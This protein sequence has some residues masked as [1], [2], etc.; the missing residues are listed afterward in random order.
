MTKTWP[1][2]SRRSEKEPPPAAIFSCQR[3]V[4]SVLLS[5]RGRVGRGHGQGGRAAKA[6][7]VSETHPAEQTALI[8]H[9]AGLCNQARGS[10]L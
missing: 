4:D 1:A 9:A 3:R 5:A 10:P 7:S 8:K 6:I 2:T